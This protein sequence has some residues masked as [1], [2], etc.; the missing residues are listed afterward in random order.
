MLLLRKHTTAFSL[1]KDI[2][3]KSDWASESKYQFSGNIGDRKKC[4]NAPWVWNQQNSD[5]GNL[6]RSNTPN[7]PTWKL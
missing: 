4:Q 5:C 7:S 6:D 3:S 1:V 2:I